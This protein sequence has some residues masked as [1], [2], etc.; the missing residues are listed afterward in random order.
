MDRGIYN[1][2]VV[3][4][5]YKDKADGGKQKTVSYMLKDVKKDENGKPVYPSENPFAS[6][7][8]VKHEKATDQIDIIGDIFINDYFYFVESLVK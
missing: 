2:L 7:L 1:A 8:G 6:W 5:D 3:V 4:A